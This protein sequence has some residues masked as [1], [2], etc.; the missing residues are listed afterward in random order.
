MVLP[1]HKLIG[2]PTQLLVTEFVLNVTLTVLPVPVLLK[3]IV[4]LVHPDIGY[5]ILLKPVLHVVLSVTYV[6]VVPLTPI[7]LL[8]LLLELLF[9][10]LPTIHLLPL[11]L[12]NVL[13]VVPLLLLPPPVLLVP[14]LSGLILMSVQLVM[15]SVLP[16]GEVLPNV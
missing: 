3:L 13:P 9:Q 6:T 15:L 8:V 5:M 1:L 16:V 2:I 14:M 11:S 10:V 7:V 4:L 12:V